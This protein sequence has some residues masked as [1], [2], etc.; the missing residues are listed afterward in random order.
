MHCARVSNRFT[1][2]TSPSVCADQ[3]QLRVKSVTPA[4]SPFGG[5]ITVGVEGWE[6]AD[7]ACLSVRVHRLTEPATVLVRTARVCVALAWTQ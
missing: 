4:T 5:K 2:P 1:K 3:N 6:A 7:S